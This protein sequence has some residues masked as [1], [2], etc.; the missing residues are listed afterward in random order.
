MQMDEEQRGLTLSIQTPAQL[1]LR[2]S[3][4]RFFYFAGSG[5]LLGLLIPL[6]LLWSL[7]RFDPRLRDANQIELLA[8]LPIL[9]TVPRY[10]GMTQIRQRRRGSW[11]LAAVLAAVFLAYAA[12]CVVHL[13]R[14]P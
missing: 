11:Q 1:P 3:G 2:P 6:G 9:A 13:A 7:L 5:L 14:I 4:P 10:I 12:V 8:G